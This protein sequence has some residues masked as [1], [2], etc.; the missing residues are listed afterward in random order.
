MKLEKIDIN[1]VSY[2]NYRVWLEQVA[3]KKQLMQKAENERITTNA[4]IRELRA[5]LKEKYKKENNIVENIEKLKEELINA[6][7]NKF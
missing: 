5:V 7:P 4:E 1:K 2:D 3:Y 6:L